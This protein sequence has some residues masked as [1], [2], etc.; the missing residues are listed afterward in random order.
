MDVSGF[1][2]RL[3]QAYRFVIMDDTTFEEKVV[4][5]LTPRLV[6][7]LSFSAIVLLIAL[8][9]AL[10][11][12][13][14]LREYIPGYGNE[15]NLQKM[16]HLQAQIDSMHRLIASIS[17]YE[18][19]VKK[20]FTNGVFEEDS[21]DLYFKTTTTTEKNAF[22]FSEFDSILLEA[23]VKKA[24]LA[25]NMVTHIKQKEQNRSDLFFPPVKG[26]VQQKYTLE[27][28]GIKLACK[29]GTPVFAPT[30]GMVIYTRYTSETGTCIILLHPNNIVTIYQQAG[31]TSLQTGDYVKPKQIISTID[32]ETSLVFELWINGSFVNPEEYILF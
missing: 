28:K 20:I 1:K 17:T 26:V 23:E 21:T 11:A 10:V 25:K 27:S 3:R 19:N 8:T 15:Q 29:K 12:F 32:S 14:P 16:V 4:F 7:T 22:A 13:T 6:A 2:Q 9:I 18:Q 31:K 24:A 30:A 5:R